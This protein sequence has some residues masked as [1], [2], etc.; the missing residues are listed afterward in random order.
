MLQELLI[1]FIT[2]GLAELLDKS[3]LSLLLLATR[4]K[5]TI[6]L[7][8]GAMLGFFVVDGLAVL[9]GAWITT[10]IPQDILRFIAAGL[11][12]IFGLLALRTAS[13]KP[14]TKPDTRNPFFAGFLTILFVEWGDKT[15]LATA[16]FATQFNPFLV[17]LA[18]MAALFL[19]SLAAVLVGQALA[20]RLNKKKINLLSGVAFIVIG[21]F[22]LFS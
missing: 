7:L 2:I 21:I 16:A 8:A 4:T 9:L 11:F 22:F 5:R 1:P 17:L 15:Q 3:Q 6:T 10:V 14:D 19:I 20:A 12:I 18:I 13:E